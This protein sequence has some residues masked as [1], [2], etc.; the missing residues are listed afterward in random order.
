MQFH[1]HEGRSKRFGK[2]IDFPPCQS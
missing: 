1:L 2:Q